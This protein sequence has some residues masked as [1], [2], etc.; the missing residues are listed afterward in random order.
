MP[1]IYFYYKLY[2]NNFAILYRFLGRQ[3]LLCR[4][5]QDC[6]KLDFLRLYKRFPIGQMPFWS[7]FRR[8]DLN[9]TKRLNFGNR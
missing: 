2:R 3:R 7:P 9:D 6:N 1:T 8:L 4:D 5:L